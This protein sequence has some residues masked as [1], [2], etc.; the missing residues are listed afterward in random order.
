MYNDA[1]QEARNYLNEVLTRDSCVYLCHLCSSKARTYFR[2]HNELREAEEYAKK[3]GLYTS[4]KW[5]F[6][7]TQF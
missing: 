2:L 6:A 3:P 1:C 7:K 5:S 4:H